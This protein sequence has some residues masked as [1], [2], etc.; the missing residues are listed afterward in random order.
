MKTIETSLL[1]ITLFL[2]ACDSRSRDTK[3]ASPANQQKQPTSASEGFLGLADDKS[4]KIGD[5]S[6]DSAL[7]GMTSIT[8]VRLST[9]AEYDRAR[10]ERRIKTQETRHGYIYYSIEQTMHAPFP[11]GSSAYFTVTE[12]FKTKMP[13]AR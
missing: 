7:A 3:Q 8:E 2:S 13:D 4:K 11:N 9:S 1:S 5:G 10:V 12:R 6:P